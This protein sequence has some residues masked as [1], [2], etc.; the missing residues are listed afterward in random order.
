MD[1]SLV[2]LLKLLVDRKGTDLHI[3]HNTP[4]RLRVNGSLEPEESIVLSADQCKE[5][6]FSV[7]TEKQK[8]ILE[9][10]R[11]V[12]IAFNVK[13]LARF[14]GSIFL[15]MGVLNAAFRCI[16]LT[17]RTLEELDV[18]EIVNEL[19]F[20]RR[21]LILVTGPTGSGKTATINSMVDFMNRNREDHILTIENP[22]E[23]IHESK[24]SKITHRSVGQDINTYSEGVKGALRQDPDIVYL[25]EL[26]DRD[27]VQSALTI[28]ETG[29]LVISS[30]HTNGTVNTLSRIVDL[31]PA[32]RNQQ[33]RTQLSTSLAAIISLQLI[34]T[35]SETMKL[36]ME[37]LKPNIAIRSMIAE[38]KLN[39]IYSHMQT[40]QENTHMQTMNQELAR[41]VYQGQIE[42]ITAFDYSPEQEELLNM[43]DNKIL[44]DRTKAS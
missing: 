20:L 2:Q 33:I 32:N 13:G 22:V 44:K 42:R 24:K 41:L 36:L 18:P 9:E 26:N 16:P 43:L 29:H 12:D 11:E 39:Q 15:S 34:N 28:A 37:I 3:S 14:R 35:K 10:N 4:I 17:L 38:G 25:G 1:I 19:C 5:L 21:G 23:Y 40:G 7:L 27:S 8:R 30:L 6:C 31:F